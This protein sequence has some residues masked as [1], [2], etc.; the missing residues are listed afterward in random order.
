MCASGTCLAMHRRMT[1]RA[2]LAATLLVGCGQ[3]G[4]IGGDDDDGPPSGPPDTT[5]PQLVAIP[6]VGWLHQPIRITLDEP[7]KTTGAFV[8][9]EL[10][11]APV[12]ATLAI[13][14]SS[15][16]VMLDPAA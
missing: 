12:D 7:L 8:H 13:D 5:P 3:M 1:S 9:A 2:A 16:I 4:T 6:P 14:G 15:V 11:G 10:A